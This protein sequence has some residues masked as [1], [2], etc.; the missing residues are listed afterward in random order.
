MLNS[1]CFCTPNSQ[2]LGESQ[3]IQNP[4]RGAGIKRQI[5]R[6]ISFFLR[7]PPLSLLSTF[8]CLLSPW[9]R[10]HLIITEQS[11]QAGTSSIA[12]Q[13]KVLLIFRSWDADKAG[14]LVHKAESSAHLLAAVPH[15]STLLYV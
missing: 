1:G 10:T 2:G 3:K 11:N 13:I 14:L 4:F 9:S 15:E 7:A 5:K 6:V 12:H 8:L